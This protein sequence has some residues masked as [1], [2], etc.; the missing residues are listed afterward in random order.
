[1][2]KMGSQSNKKIKVDTLM[3]K[4]KKQAKSK[5]MASKGRYDTP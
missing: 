4:T 3:S 1:M 5:E 2:N